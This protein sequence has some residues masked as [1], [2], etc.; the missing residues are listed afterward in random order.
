MRFQIPRSINKVLF[1]LQSATLS[2]L[3][4]QLGSYFSKILLRFKKV[5]KW[6]F[7]SSSRVYGKTE[8]SDK[9]SFNI[10]LDC[11][12]LKELGAKLFVQWASVHHSWTFW[13]GK[14]LMLLL[15]NLFRLRVC[16][17]GYERRSFK[18]RKI[19]N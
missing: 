3:L 13:K 19:F 14:K 16:D 7:I 17:G 8:N 18:C 11:A 4:H 5:K 6:Q 2:K 9:Y 10:N 15:Q 1:P 12:N